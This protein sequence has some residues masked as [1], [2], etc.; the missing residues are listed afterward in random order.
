MLAKHNAQ[1]WPGTCSRTG[2][3]LAEA[4]E[5][6]AGAGGLLR[7]GR[8]GLAGRPPVRQD[9]RVVARPQPELPE[10]QR[11]LAGRL[12]LHTQADACESLFLCVH[13]VLKLFFMSTPCL[14][15]VWSKD[16]MVNKTMTHV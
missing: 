7:E 16:A 9:A 1:G 5:R 4:G 10:L 2:Q 8:G 13:H 6:E 14:M 3:A 12:R 15:W 11:Q